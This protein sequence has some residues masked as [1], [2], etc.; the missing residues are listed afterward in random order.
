MKKYFNSIALVIWGLVLTAIFS[1]AIVSCVDMYVGGIRGQETIINNLI[2]SVDIVHARIS[3]L[4]KKMTEQEA[5]IDF[6]NAMFDL[7][8]IDYE[9][10]QEYYMERVK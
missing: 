9:K 1:W 6:M 4:E 5:Q 2:Q 7:Q 10:M 8:L 3:V